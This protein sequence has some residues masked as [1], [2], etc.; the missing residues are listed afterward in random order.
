[1]AARNLWP[2]IPLSRE[3]IGIRALQPLQQQAVYELISAVLLVVIECL[4][5]TEHADCEKLFPL[6]MLING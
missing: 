3:A 5:L 2:E 6:I 4:G 1:M